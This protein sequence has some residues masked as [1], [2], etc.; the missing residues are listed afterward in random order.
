MAW[1]GRHGRPF[2]G[3]A[4]THAACLFATWGQAKAE[5]FFLELK[6]NHVQLMGN[7]KQVAVAVGAGQLA[8]GLIDTDDAIAEIDRLMPVAIVYPDQGDGQL[9]TLFIPNTISVLKG[10]TIRKPRGGWSASSCRR[11]SRR[12]WPNLRAQ[13]PLRPDVE[14]TSRLKIP[15]RVHQ[16]E[17]DFGKAGQMWDASEEF[18]HREFNGAMRRGGCR[19]EGLPKLPP[20]KG[21]MRSADYTDFADKRVRLTFSLE[22]CVHLRNLWT[23]FS[24]LLRR[25]RRSSMVAP[26]PFPIKLSGSVAKMAAAQRASG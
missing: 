3:T 1:A 14:A 23:V 8:F 4:A 16:M 15:E 11:R 12:S 24:S 7:N 10:C 19:R 22:I 26:G 25:E 20:Q 21:E 13:I 9:G 2:A 18:L 6:D 17:V 5:Q